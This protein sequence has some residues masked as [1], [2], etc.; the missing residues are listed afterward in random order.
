M[1]R[2]G[3]GR[4]DDGVG[5][6]GLAVRCGWKSVWA[7]PGLVVGGCLQGGLISLNMMMGYCVTPESAV[8][9][10]ELVG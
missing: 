4:V 7:E 8:H 3:S 10:V 2:S 5:E 1:P 6:L 9:V